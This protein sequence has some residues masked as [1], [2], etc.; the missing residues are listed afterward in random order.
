MIQ[1]HSFW[2]NTFLWMSYITVLKCQNT[3]MNSIRTPSISQLFKKTAQFKIPFLICLWSYISKIQI[4]CRIVY[5]M[6]FPII[7]SLILTFL[8]FV[9]H[10]IQLSLCYFLNIQEENSICERQTNSIPEIKS[11]NRTLSTEN[12]I[13]HFIMMSELLQRHFPK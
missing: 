2:M 7:N 10:K 11:R 3:Q 6:M 4:Y 8:Q 5:F 13:I 12:R 9:N 1:L